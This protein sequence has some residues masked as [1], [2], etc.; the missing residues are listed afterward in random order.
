MFDF[1][2]WYIV[3]IFATFC[4]AKEFFYTLRD[5]EKWKYIYWEIRHSLEHIWYLSIYLY[6]LVTYL[7]MEYTWVD[8]AYFELMIWIATIILTVHLSWERH[9]K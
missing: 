8:S 7:V 3:L 9:H 4:V 1:N 2:Y 5:I 6:G